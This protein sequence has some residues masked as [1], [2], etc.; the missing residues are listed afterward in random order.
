MPLTRPCGCVGLSEPLLVTCAKLPL[1]HELASFIDSPMQKHSKSIYILVCASVRTCEDPQESFI[2]QFHEDAALITV[3]VN[4]ENHHA[5][6]YK[7]DVC[8]FKAQLIRV[9]Y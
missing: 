1:S 8:I 3:L 7:I 5:N 6:S 9:P 4:L 2:L